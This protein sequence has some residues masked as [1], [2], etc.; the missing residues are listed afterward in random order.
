MIELSA[1]I[2]LLRSV[3][4]LTFPRYYRLRVPALRVLFH[5]NEN[6]EPEAAAGLQKRAQLPW[7][8][9]EKTSF[10]NWDYQRIS[11]GFQRGNQNRWDWDHPAPFK[12]PVGLFVGVGGQTPPSHSQLPLPGDLSFVL[13]RLCVN[14]SLTA[15]R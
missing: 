3:M 12:G 7:I 11:A 9:L 4:N 15:S 6:V 2:P 5:V 1:L 8:V 14:G 13:Q 10:P